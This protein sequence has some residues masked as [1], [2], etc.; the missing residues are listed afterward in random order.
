MSTQPSKRL[1]TT[2]IG[3]HDYEVDFRNNEFR[4]VDKPSNTIPMWSIN[5]VKDEFVFLYDNAAAKVVATE[6]SPSVE[7]VVLDYQKLDPLWFKTIRREQRE[8][9]KLMD[10]E[11]SL[12]DRHGGIHA[13]AP[14][15]N[16]PKG[17]LPVVNLYGTD[18]FLDLRL[19]E[20]RAVED[21]TKRISWDHVDDSDLNIQ[22]WYDATAKSG[23]NGTYQQALD[24]GNVKWITLPPLDQL[25]REGIARHD[26][27]VKAAAQS[28]QAPNKI[29][30][31]DTT[32]M[33]S[34][35]RKKKF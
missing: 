33:N 12:Y 21:H 34:R 30:K 9:K 13:W 35:H 11:E 14:L 31:P 24:H 6:S 19:A 23:F 8:A 18:F 25:V 17:R 4:Q 20:F 7:R 3:Q 26:D 29:M 5:L 2:K 27:L 16:N 10:K 22:I 15:P 1:P 32:R 28:Q